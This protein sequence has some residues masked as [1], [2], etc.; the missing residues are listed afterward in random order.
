[1]GPYLKGLS[2]SIETGH[3]GLIE[4]GRKNIAIAF[5]FEMLKTTAFLTAARP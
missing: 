4:Q 2:K 3:G 5:T 1:M